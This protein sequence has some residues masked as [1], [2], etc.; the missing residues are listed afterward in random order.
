MSNEGRTC[1]N[2]Q[3]PWLLSRIHASIWGRSRRSCGSHRRGHFD[4]TCQVAKKGNSSVQRSARSLDVRVA[5]YVGSAWS[6]VTGGLRERT[7]IEERS[8][9]RPGVFSNRSETFIVRNGVL[10]MSASIRSG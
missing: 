10:T 6:R 5:P 8:A 9:K 4:I 7:L 3:Q 2:H 1:P